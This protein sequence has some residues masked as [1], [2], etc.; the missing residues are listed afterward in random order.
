MLGEQRVVV[1]LAHEL[2]AR[3]RAG[4]ACRGRRRPSAARAGARAAARATCAAS[5]SLSPNVISSV[6]VE[7]FSFT[8]GTTSQREQRLE[9]GAR[10]QIARA[11]VRCRRPSAAPAPARAAG[12]GERA[13]PG[14]ERAAPARRP[15]PPAGS[16]RRAAARR[17]RAP[18]SAERDRAARDD[19]DRH[20][21]RLP[22]PRSRPASA[23]EQRAPRA[24]A[25]VHERR[26]AE[27]DDDGAAHRRYSSVSRESPPGSSVK[28][29]HVGR[30]GEPAGRALALRSRRR[31]R[32]GPRR[33]ACPSP[34]ACAR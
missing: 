14:A 13:L 26:R 6:A 5:A 22:A 31:R 8:T 2:G 28:G 27:L 4:R 12:R 3:A 24:S 20:V 21:R 17:G 18:P 11:R 34:S 32:R 25:R 1:H 30:L 19:A 16:A 15:R 9:R 7:S 29:T 10:V 23:R 33:A